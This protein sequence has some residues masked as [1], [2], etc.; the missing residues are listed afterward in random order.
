MHS[1]TSAITTIFLVSLIGLTGCNS[2]SS[3]DDPEPTNTNEPENSEQQNIENP[4]NDAS[5]NNVE[6]Q[7]ESTITS[8]IID[9][10]SS[11]AYTYFNLNTGEVVDLTEDQAA[12]SQEWHVGFKRTGLKLNGGTSGPGNVVGAVAIAQ[13]DFYD[14]SEANISVFTNATPESEEEHLLSV[15]EL[16]SLE[17]QSDADVSAITSSDATIGTTI[18]KGW[19]NYNFVQHSAAVNSDNHWLLRS[20]EGNSYAKFHATALDS[21]DGLKV[22]FEFEVQESGSTVFTETATFNASIPAEGGKDC[23]DFDNNE[24]VGCE[25]DAWDLQLEVAGR[26]WLL[27]TNSGVSGSGKGG[28]FGPFDAATA[29]EYN[30]G[31]LSPTSGNDITHHYNSDSSSG[32]FNDHTWYAY[33]LLDNH[34]LWSNYRVYV[35]DTDSTDEQ[36]PKYKFQITNYYSDTGTSG[37]PNFRYVE[38]AR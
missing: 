9:A 12:Q 22:T 15:I 7:P 36:S 8:K 23:F 28:A 31:T 24:T 1:L 20:S 29:A 26:N 27:W 30:S 33:N 25:T 37:Y 11:S 21:S 35:I 4:D 14:G 19:Y 2:S 5:N 6:E 16:A 32:I 10:T 17:F 3:S 13:D 18:D 34:K 38:I